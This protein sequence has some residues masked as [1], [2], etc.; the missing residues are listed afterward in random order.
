[1]SKRPTCWGGL[2][3]FSLCENNQ[4][5]TTEASLSFTFSTIQKKRLVQFVSSLD[6]F[7]GDRGK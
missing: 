6:L 7:C 5:K 1:L 3:L 4:V 2:F